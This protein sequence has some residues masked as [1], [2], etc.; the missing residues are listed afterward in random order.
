MKD[1]FHFNA[2]NLETS[3]G[4]I[5][6][7]LTINSY[8]QLLFLKTVELNLVGVITWYFKELF[9]LEEISY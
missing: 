6:S 1:R 2:V 8:F 3:L 7:F 4:F 5:S 9:F